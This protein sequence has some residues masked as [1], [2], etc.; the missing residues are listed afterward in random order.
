M[1]TKTAKQKLS[2]I[3]TA[4][5]DFSVYHATFTDYSEKGTQK[6]DWRV[7]RKGSEKSLS[8]TCTANCRRFPYR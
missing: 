6:F 2:D 7:R 8:G 5:L 4:A 3:L 1:E